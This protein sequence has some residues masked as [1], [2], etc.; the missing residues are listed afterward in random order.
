M[1]ATAA[2]KHVLGDYYREPTKSKDGLPTHLFSNLFRSFKNDH[3]VSDQ[4]DMVFYQ[5]GHDK[6]PVLGVVGIN[7]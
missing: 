4:G 3:F 7:N 5:K 1:Q 6:H 2:V